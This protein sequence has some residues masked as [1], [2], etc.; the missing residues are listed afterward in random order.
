MTTLVQF[1][2]KWLRVR[3]QKPAQPKSKTIRKKDRQVLPILPKTECPPIR[4]QDDDS[5]AGNRVVW[6]L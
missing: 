6:R 1:V 5:P 3:L 4:W 2:P